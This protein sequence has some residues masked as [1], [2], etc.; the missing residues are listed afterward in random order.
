MT[1]TIAPEASPTE[2]ST[3]VEERMIRRLDGEIVFESR[4][5]THRLDDV[6]FPNGVQG[7]YSVIGATEGYGVVAVPVLNYRGINYIGLVEQFRY[8]LGRQSL[9]LVRGGA[10]EPTAAEA[11]R[12][13]QE[14][15]GMVPGSAEFLGAIN[16]DTGI[17]STEVSVYLFR[18]R[19]EDKDIV[20]QEQDSGALTSWYMMADVMRLV[21]NG[22]IRCGITL[23]SLLLLQNSGRLR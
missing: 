5:I 19:P 15:T 9:E 1:D 4:F 23:A 18:Q 16:P 8:P 10:L 2:D 17:L 12:E 14:E 13:L 22:D 7:K 11:G 21:H 20:F 3:P 6:E